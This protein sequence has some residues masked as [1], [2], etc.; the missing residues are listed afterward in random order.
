MKTFRFSSSTSDD[1]AQFRSFHF[2]FPP[3]AAIAE[4]SLTGIDENDDNSGATVGFISF[5]FLD[6][7]GRP[8]EVR[9]DLGA[10]LPVVGHN[11]LIRVDFFMRLWIARASGLLNV[12]IWPDGAIA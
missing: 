10:R 9:L 11:R 1:L 4:V 3:C 6:D 12:F 2:D 8:Q 5:T 7:D